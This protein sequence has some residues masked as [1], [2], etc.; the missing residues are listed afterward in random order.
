MSTFSTFGSRLPCSLS[1]WATFRKWAAASLI[2]F[3]S[4]LVS[5]TVPWRVA[6]K[7]SVAGWAVPLARGLRAV[8]TMST[9]A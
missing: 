4:S 6:T 3:R 7:D 2:L 1:F 5:R 8:S 9:P